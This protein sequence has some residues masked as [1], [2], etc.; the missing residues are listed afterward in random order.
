MTTRSPSQS[1]YKVLFSVYDYETVSSNDCI[2]S[3]EVPIKELVGMSKRPDPIP[4]TPMAFGFSDLVLKLKVKGGG[5]GA[6][7][8]LKIGFVPYRDIRRNFWL[9][10]ANTFDSDNSNHLSNIEV[11]SYK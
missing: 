7:L 9:T 4:D 8:R 1:N 6:A 3:V 11:Y 10:L 2:G 5:E